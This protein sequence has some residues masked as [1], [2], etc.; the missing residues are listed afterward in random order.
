MT[1]ICALVC[2]LGLVLWTQ[3]CVVTSLDLFDS[4]CRRTYTPGAF[5]ATKGKLEDEAWN[6]FHQ[7]EV[8]VEHT[9]DQAST[10]VVWARGTKVSGIG[11]LMQ[12]RLDD[13]VLAEIDVA[14]EAFAPYTVQ[15]QQMSVPRRLSVVFLNDA[16]KEDQDRNLYIE[17]VEVVCAAQCQ[18]SHINAKQMDASAGV[19]SA[20]REAKLRGAW[21]L[22]NEGA[23]S[24]S[25]PLDGT[26]TLSVMARG[27]FA[28]EWPLME[29]RI[30]DRALERR[31]VDRATFERYD[32]TIP[33][34]F[35]PTRSARVS[36]AFLNDFKDADADRNLHIASAR[37]LCASSA[38]EQP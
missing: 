21:N 22:S 1:K 2:L 7:G 18:E 15:I 17:R 24:F 19:A 12:I 11:P 27:D 6:L 38:F 23:L 35:V 30:D 16:I 9:F 34:G 37:V 28:Q 32:F 29:V 36:I 14:T 3:G 4:P 26:E 20:D 33:E 8:F 5:S 13:E 25:H 31:R 10:V